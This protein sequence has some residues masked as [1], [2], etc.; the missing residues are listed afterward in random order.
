MIDV[1][2]TC[3]WLPTILQSVLQW[4][5]QRAVGKSSL[6]HDQHVW[7]ITM[8]IWDRGVNLTDQHISYYSITQ[9]WTPKWWKKVFWRMVDISV[10]N[11]WIIYCLNS[12]STE[13]TSH[14]LFRLE[15]AHELVQPLLLLKATPECPLSYSK[16]WISVGEETAKK[17][18][19]IQTVSEGNVHS[20]L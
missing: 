4:N 9:R 20:V 13:S 16:G 6:F 2:C 5:K 3:F 10:L 1:M 17:A 15:L 7:W 8:N 14:R 12:P 19:S 11:A 18:F